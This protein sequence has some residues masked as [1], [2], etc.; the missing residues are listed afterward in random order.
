[1]VFV[2]SR[3]C[4]TWQNLKMPPLDS[5]GLYISL[6]SQL[7]IQLRALV[8]K[9]FWGCDVASNA[10][11]NLNLLDDC[12][13][14]Y[15]DEQCRL[16]VYSHRRCGMVATYRDIANIIQALRDQ[17]L[18]RESL[19][20]YLQKEFEIS[21][22]SVESSR[23]SYDDSEDFSNEL[24][25]LA[26]RLWLMIP[27]GGFRQV[28]LHGESLDWPRGYL[29]DALCRQFEKSSQNPV[30]ITLGKVFNARNLE[31]IGGLRIIWTSNLVDHLRLH[32]D[33][34][35]LSIFHHATFLHYQKN[36]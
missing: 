24:I 12:Y 8:V 25:E 7:P 28:A 27:I 30:S 6:H 3:T 19:R 33:D 29:Q 13:F 26:V 10:F 18:D 9:E 2:A 20:E 36:W 17:S 31:R 16:A 15:H 5:D 23:S 14:L 11:R 22:S 32:D 4:I 34:T 1:M 21:E 35:R